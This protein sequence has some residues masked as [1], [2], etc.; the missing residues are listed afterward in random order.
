MYANAITLPTGALAKHCNVHVCVC[1]SAG[2]FSELCL[3]NGT[4]YQQKTVGKIWYALCSGTSL[5][6]KSIGLNEM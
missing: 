5:K 6:V 1:V 2:I 4:W 3:W